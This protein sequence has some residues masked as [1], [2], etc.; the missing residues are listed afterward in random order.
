[1]TIFLRRF[2]FELVADAVDRMDEL[3]FRVNGLDLPPQFFDVA[4]YRAVTDVALIRIDFVHKLLATVDASWIGCQESQQFELYCSEVQI[5]AV[6]RSLVAVLVEHEPLELKRLS[7][8]RPAQ[9][10][11]DPC[12]HLTGTERFADVVIRAKFKSQ[13]AV[14]FFYPGCYHNNRNTGE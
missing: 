13:N 3:R 10:S 6:Q 4:V 1:M 9:N 7:V 5:M 12:D 14:Y 8:R 2:Q 11:L